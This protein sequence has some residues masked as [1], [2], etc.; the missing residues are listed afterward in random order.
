MA[1]SEEAA[2]LTLITY[3]SYYSNSCLAARIYS[4]TLLHCIWWV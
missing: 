2:T 1:E 4:R 3:I